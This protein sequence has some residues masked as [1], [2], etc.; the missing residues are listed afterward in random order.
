MRSPAPDRG[1]DVVAG[2]PDEDGDRPDALSVTS[3]QQDLDLVVGIAGHLDLATA[4][5]LDER[6]R[7]RHTQSAPR[8]ILLDL[9]QVEF[10]GCAGVAVLLRLQRWACDHGCGQPRLARTT[11]A[12]DRALS[13]LGAWDLFERSP[14]L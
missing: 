14:D 2:G 6:L 5:L 11:S 1:T 13:L 7:G 10:L 8:R 9:S 12:A 4:P 3:V